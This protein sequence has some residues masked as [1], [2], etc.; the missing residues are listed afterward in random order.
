VGGGTHRSGQLGPG[1]EADRGREARYLF[2]TNECVGLGHLRRSLTLATA[3]Q[4]ADPRGSSLI[5][6]GSPADLEGGRDQGIDTV[7]LP[8][9]HRDE[10]GNYGS[11]SLGM[12]SASLFALRSQLALATA[13]AWG[14]DLVVVDKVPLGLG[15]ELRETLT[16]LR[17]EGSCRIVL[18]LRDIEDDPVTV[19]RRWTRDGTKQVLRELYDGVLVYGPRTSQDALHC[20]GGDDL[21]LPVRHVGYVGA[22]VPARPA[23]DLP[24]GYLLVTTGG[25]VDG[26][27]VASAVIQAVRLRPLG[28]RVV[29]VAGPLM[30][31]ERVAALTEQAAGTDVQVLGSRRDLAAV[32][33]GARAV[34][35]MAGYNTVSEVL[36]AGKPVLL[37]PRVR[38]SSEQLLRASQL[39]ADGVAAVLHPDELTPTSM[40]T[41]LDELLRRDP[42]T[43]PP[44]QYDGATRAAQVLTEM[45]RW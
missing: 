12:P 18:G 28:L 38:P 35:C 3:V 39:A 7:K 1:A 40:R 10:T 34:V 41:A 29:V 45:A 19:R 14:P 11:R 21:G 2:F 37:V 36:R 43:C 16:T 25:G 8:A 31:P 42:P 6:T 27:A 4:A 20:V 26:F 30:A 13:L 32:V 9:L 22:P 33:V 15:E 44:D 23:P 5:V 17:R 24:P